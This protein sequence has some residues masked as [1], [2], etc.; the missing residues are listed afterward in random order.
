MSKTFFRGFSKILFEST[1]QI[2]SCSSS[3]LKSW[4]STTFSIKNISKFKMTKMTNCKKYLLLLFVGS[5]VHDEIRKKTTRKQP[6][7]TNVVF[8]IKIHKIRLKM[9]WRIL[10]LQCRNASMRDNRVSRCQKLSKIAWRHFWM[11]PLLNYFHLGHVRVKKDVDVP[12][13][14]INWL[15]NKLININAL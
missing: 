13:K 7:I 1:R 3:K 11:T 9:V 2:M 12:L 5:K 14:A 4:S 10:W 15:V 8:I 6:Y